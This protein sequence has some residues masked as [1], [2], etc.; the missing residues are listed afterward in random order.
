MVREPTGTRANQGHQN[1]PRSTLE[2]KMF[3]ACSKVTKMY[4]LLPIFQTFCSNAC[5]TRTFSDRLP[6]WYTT[7]L[8][9]PR[10]VTCRPCR[11]NGCRATLDPVS[12]IDD[13]W[14][15]TLCDSR[16]VSVMHAEDKIL[17]MSVAVQVFALPR[18]LAEQQ[19]GTMRRLEP[20]H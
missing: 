14:C 16:G 17:R 4:L 13:A 15:L 3:T 5:L 1:H 2:R 20:L 6:S 18:R 12:N 10:K 11:T 19:K 8:V 7:T 9:I